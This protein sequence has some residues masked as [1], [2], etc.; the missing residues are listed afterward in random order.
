[1][2]GNESKLPAIHMQTVMLR[3]VVR[4]IRGLNG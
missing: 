3:V 1:M 2:F 4:D